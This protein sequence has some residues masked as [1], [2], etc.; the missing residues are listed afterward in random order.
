MATS[1]AT[2][3]FNTLPEFEE[4]FP[5]TILLS[6]SLWTLC[7]C[8]C[9]CNVSLFISSR[10]TKENIQHRQPRFSFV[11]VCLIREA[12]V[13]TKMFFGRFCFLSL[14]RKIFVLASN[15]FPKLRFS[16]K[17]IQSKFCFNKKQDALCMYNMNVSLYKQPLTSSF[18]RTAA[19]FSKVLYSFLDLKEKA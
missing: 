17:T 11:N 13:S 1:K 8:V 18:G 19:S 16:S 12:T 10:G 14:H 5:R 9:V 4:F 6:S 3:R 7:V 15:D 2:L